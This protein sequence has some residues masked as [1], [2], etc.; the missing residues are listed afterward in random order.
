MTNVD[1]KWY[2]REL[3]RWDDF[4]NEHHR[5]Y[6]M[7]LEELSNKQLFPSHT[8]VAAIGS[9][10]S[11]SPQQ[12]E[13]D[14]RPYVH[15]AIDESPVRQVVEAYLRQTGNM[16]KLFSRNTAHSLDQKDNVSAE[17][18]RSH[19]R[20]KSSDGSSTSARR[21]PDRWCMCESADGGTVKPIFLGEYKPARKLRSAGFAAL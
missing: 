6:N 4:E 15:G 9:L 1:G 14:V 16:D 3:H 5:I 21:N 11:E 17:D 2:P 20:N 19:P 18:E 13:L 12:A 8:Q 10:L 7:L